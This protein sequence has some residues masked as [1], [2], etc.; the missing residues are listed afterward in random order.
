MQ[1]GNSAKIKVLALKV[2][3]QLGSAAAH[4]VVAYAELHPEENVWFDNGE[5]RLQVGD[6]RYIWD[7]TLLYDAREDIEDKKTRIQHGFDW[8]HIDV[9]RVSLA[10]VVQRETTDRR[11]IGAI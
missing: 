10:A 6:W 5:Q 11:S 2:G 3:Q 8:E 7:E 1:S 9:S 4:E